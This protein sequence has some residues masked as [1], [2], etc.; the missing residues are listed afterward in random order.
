MLCKSS[1]ISAS[2]YAVWRIGVRAR[3][4]D[5]EAEPEAVKKAYRNPLKAVGVARRER[6]REP[7]SPSASLQRAAA[8]ISPPEHQRARDDEGLLEGMRSNP[9]GSIGDWWTD[10]WQVED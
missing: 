7:A 4:A 2:P 1:V 9:A 10:G 6:E 5:I 8:P 3:H